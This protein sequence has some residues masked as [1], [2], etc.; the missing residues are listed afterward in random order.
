VAP[1][2]VLSM[3]PLSKVMSIGCR[4]DG[5]I[6]TSV[7]FIAAIRRD[8][9]IPA[10][11]GCICSVSGSKALTWVSTRLD[12][13][14]VCWYR[15]APRYIL[16]YPHSS[17]GFLPSNN[18]P[19]STPCCSLISLLTPSMAPPATRIR[20]ARAPRRQQTGTTQGSSVR[21]SVCDCEIH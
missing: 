9:F 20:K 17:I 10:R 13:Q 19:P 21:Q 14:Y 8:I 6:M 12:V 15:C 18:H 11:H 3:G 1:P 16:Q 7:G 2:S 4:G 5:S